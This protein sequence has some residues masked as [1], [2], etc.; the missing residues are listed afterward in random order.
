M[1]SATTDVSQSLIIWNLPF[2][3]NI[4]L[5]TLPFKHP[6]HSISNWILCELG[7]EWLSVCPPHSSHCNVWTGSVKGLTVNNARPAF[8]SHSNICTVYAFLPDRHFRRRLVAQ[9]AA[10]PSARLCCRSDFRCLQERGWQLQRGCWGCWWLSG[11]S[12]LG[13]LNRQAE[14]ELGQGVGWLS[15]VTGRR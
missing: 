2:F 1:I 13:V 3:H 14:R 4:H 5:S 10:H 6:P 7:R 9:P 8:T 11:G 15:S 12:E